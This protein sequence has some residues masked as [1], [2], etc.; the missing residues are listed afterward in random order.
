MIRPLLLIDPDVPPR[1]SR[2]KF[3][4][5][6]G[7]L[8][9]CLHREIKFKMTVFFEPIFS[10]FGGF[11]MI[12]VFYAKSGLFFVSVSMIRV[13]R[14]L[15]LLAFLSA[16]SASFCSYFLAFSFSSFFLFLSFFL[17]KSMT[18]ICSNSS[19]MKYYI[20]LLLISY[21]FLSLKKSVFLLSKDKHYGAFSKVK[22]IKKTIDE[23]FL[24][25][26]YPPRSPISSCV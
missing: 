14:S 2:K 13:S 25:S 7:C 1:S 16:I 18:S 5:C 24:S 21:S 19:L 12:L 17:A 3:I 23:Q 8:S 15:Y 6:S 26:L 22:Q 9:S 4:T 11:N 20:K 10:T